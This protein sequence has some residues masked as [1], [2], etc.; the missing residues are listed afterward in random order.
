MIKKEFRRS[1]LSMVSLIFIWRAVIFV[2]QKRVAFLQPNPF[3]STNYFSFTINLSYWCAFLFIY[4]FVWSELLGSIFVEIRIGKRCLVQRNIS[5]LQSLF[6][7]F[8]TS[9]YI[10]VTILFGDGISGVAIGLMLLISFIM[11][12]L[13]QKSF[14][15][16][17]DEGISIFVLA[18]VLLLVFHLVGTYT[19]Y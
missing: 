11:I 18:T 19:V 15:H 4:R 14:I 7:V 10:A 6:A 13:L 5:M 3:E 1:I 16:G 17:V 9:A 12:F 2:L 8:N